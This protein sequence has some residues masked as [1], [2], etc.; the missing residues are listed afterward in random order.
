MGQLR[1]GYNVIFPSPEAAVKA[2]QI[3]K[4]LAADQRNF[5]AC[6]YEGGTKFYTLDQKGDFPVKIGNEMVPVNTRGLGSAL[7]DVLDV[8]RGNVIEARK[9]LMKS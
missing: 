1:L 4:H 7:Q 8:P 2:E 5:Y 3:Y 9:Y 6:E